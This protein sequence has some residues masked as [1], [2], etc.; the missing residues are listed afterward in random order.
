MEN[1]IRS[2]IAVGASTAVNCQQCLQSSINNATQDG[3]DERD[4]AIAIGVGKMVRKGAATK[5]DKF[6]ANQ[7]N[8]IS[9][10]E[11][12]ADADSGS[13]CGCHESHGLS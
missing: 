1:R 11:P 6:I 4:I 13:D 5:M 2:L 9:S 3:A 12:S 7:K 10:T 8:L